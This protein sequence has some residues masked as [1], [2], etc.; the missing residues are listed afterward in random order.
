MSCRFPM[1]I[2]IQKDCCLPHKFAYK[3]KKTQ[4]NTA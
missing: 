1:E 3:L 2:F 4:S